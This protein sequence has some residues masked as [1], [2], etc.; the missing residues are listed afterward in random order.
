MV[1]LREEAMLTSSTFRADKV[2]A[3]QTDTVA[4]AAAE[5]LDRDWWQSI[6]IPPLVP[7]VLESGPVVFFKEET[8][9]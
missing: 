9:G 3:R 8:P 7:L 6:A 1:W 2:D 4:A 5:G